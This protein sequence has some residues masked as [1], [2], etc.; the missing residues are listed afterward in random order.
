[1][2]DYKRN[3]DMPQATTTELALAKI[4]EANRHTVPTE[5][6]HKRF[7]NQ[8]TRPTDLLEHGIKDNL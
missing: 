3:K 4:T 7:R 2:K 1:M 5:C 8:F 6:R